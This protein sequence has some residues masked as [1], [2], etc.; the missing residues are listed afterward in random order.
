M[1]PE[2][3]E[4][5]IDLRP[6]LAPGG[7]RQNTDARFSANASRSDCAAAVS[8]LLPP[9]LSRTGAQL[10]LPRVGVCGVWVAVST[11][12]IDARS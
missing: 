5:T 12:A 1:Q 2:S 9:S 6:G 11:Q 7:S 8:A 10:R 4:S 3:R